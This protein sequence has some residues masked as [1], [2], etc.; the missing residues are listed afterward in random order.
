MK[1]KFVLNGFGEDGNYLLM[2]VPNQNVDEHLLEKEL[3][4]I[5]YRVNPG[6]D[7]KFGKLLPGYK[8]DTVNSL[9]PQWIISGPHEDGL[10]HLAGISV[11]PSQLDDVIH[12]LEN[13][14]NT[15]GS[16]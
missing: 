4:P 14:G 6:L 10:S 3:L 11:H 5:F 8:I 9:G 16:E 2:I 1:L 13:L 15:V 7:N 12:E